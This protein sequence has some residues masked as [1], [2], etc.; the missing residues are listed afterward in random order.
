MSLGLII[1]LLRKNQT[2]DFMIYLPLRR[3]LQHVHPC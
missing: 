1:V 2:I 3:L